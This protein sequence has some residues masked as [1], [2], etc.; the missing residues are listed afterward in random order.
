MSNSANTINTLLIP[1]AGLGT[2]LRPITYVTPKELLRLVDMPIAYYLLAE[3]HKAGIMRVIIITHEDNRK[4]MQFF[5][6]HDGAAVLASLP[7]LQVEFVETTERRGDGQALLQAEKLVE[8]PFAVTMGDLITLP[9]ESILAELVERFHKDRQAIISVEQVP[10][11]KTGQYGII[12]VHSSQDNV[13]RV[14][15]IV[16]KPAPEV[17]PSNLAMTGKYVLHSEIFRYLRER[18]QTLKEAPQPQGKPPELKLADA[19]DRYSKEFELYAMEPRTR[20]YDTGTK[21]DLF[22][23]EVAFTLAHPELGAKARE[24][25]KKFKL[26]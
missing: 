21:S 11:E 12:N 1:A 18:E 17:A 13:H 10:R 2:R 26:D 20:H 8:G 7:G 19:L 15:G 24:A 3:A 14:Y 23:A 5:E 9:G 22:V 25:L 16:E 6:S 4:T